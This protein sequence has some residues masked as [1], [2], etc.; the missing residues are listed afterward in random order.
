MNGSHSGTL[1]A[2]KFRQALDI[3]STHLTIDPSTRLALPH[4]LH[5]TFLAMVLVSLFIVLVAAWMPSIE[6][7]R[8]LTEVPA[9][10]G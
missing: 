1:M 6:L 10:E 3:G 8:S 7:G 2:E 4:A 5:F 9:T